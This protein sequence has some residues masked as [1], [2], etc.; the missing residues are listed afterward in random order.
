MTKV[1]GRH[2][3]RWGYSVNF[4]YLDHWQPESNNPRGNFNFASNAT[5]LNASGQPA[6]NIYNNFAAFMLGATSSVAKSVQAEL[7]TGRE[8]QHALYIRDRW[9]VNTRLTLDLGLRWE[10]YP[11]MTRADGRGMERLDLNSSPLE[12]I[13]GGRG[14][15]EKNVGLEPGLDNFAPRVGGIYRLN[16]QTVVRSGYGITYNAMGWARPMRGD[17]NYP[18][19]IFSSFTQPLQFGYYNLLNEGIPLILPPDQSS[20]RV[21]LPNAAGIA[22]PEPGN[23][24]RGLVQTWNVAFERPADVEHHRRRRLRWR[25][26]F[27]RIRLGRRQPADHVWRWRGEP[28]V[29]HQPGPPE[30][31]SV[32]GAAARY[33]VQ[34]PADRPEQAVH[35]R[36]HVQGR[37]HAQQGDERVGQRRPHRPQLGASARAAPQLGARRLRS[38]AQ[39]PARICLRAAVAEHQWL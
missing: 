32:L 4:L 29:F 12:M 36:V 3:L 11:I 19:V 2:D 9:N 5:R 13:L 28:A 20:G 30:L 34:L 10:Y 1:A 39:L 14:G 27:G 7:M 33:G 37:L 17:L 15:N 35:Q 26:R 8:W 31:H 22:T 24:D 18:I 6:A 23:V 38:H 21:V 25:K 16:D